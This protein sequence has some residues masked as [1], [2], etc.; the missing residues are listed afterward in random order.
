MLKAVVSPKWLVS[1]GED[2]TACTGNL[3]QHLTTQGKGFPLALGWAS[4][5]PVLWL[6]V[7]GSCPPSVLLWEEPSSVFSTLSCWGR[8]I[9]LY[10]SPLRTEK[11]HLSLHIMSYS[12]LNIKMALWCTCSTMSIISSVLG[13][14]KL[15]TARNVIPQVLDRGEKPSFLFC[16]WLLSS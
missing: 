8:H 4:N 12:P 7:T 15:D 16:C 1:L 6:L 5:I 9:E 11:T 14:P 3:L 2:S 13:S 10:L